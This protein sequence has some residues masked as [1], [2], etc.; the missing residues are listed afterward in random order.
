MLRT[1]TQTRSTRET[2]AKAGLALLCAS[3]ISLSGCFI[4]KTTARPAAMGFHV[5]RPVLPE[6]TTD[7]TLEAPSV[8]PMETRFMPPPLA[9]SHSAP[10][11][12]HVA[13]QPAP[14]RATAEKTE[15]PILAPELTSQE[16][17]AAKEE[18]QR[19]LEAAEKNLTATSGKN[20]NATQQ[21]LASKVRGFTNS[22]RE[23]MREADWERA[24]N[25]SKK[26]VVLS[27]QLVTSL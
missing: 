19:N 20:L 24:R 22:A 26:A 11:R 3:A 27:E 6:T 13:A 2:A 16:L 12:P 14:E 9:I 17:T 25:L 7:Q 5:E 23:A 8:V 21:D 4:K 1:T 15:E 10:A 18:T